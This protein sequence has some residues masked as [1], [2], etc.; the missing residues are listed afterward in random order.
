MPVI[1]VTPAGNQLYLVDLRDGRSSRHEVVLPTPLIERL[2]TEGV[3]MRDVVVAAIEFL[4]D[5]DGRDT[6]PAAI[7]LGEVAREESDGRF[8]DHLQTRAH[9]VT[10]SAP[11]REGPPG[12][13]PSQPS[14]D[15]RLLA[16]VQQDQADGAASR[17]PRK[18]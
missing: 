18:L 17:Q 5:R 4:I 3:A 7:D 12:T 6:L 11:P 10:D 8:V 16:E 1:E 14:G 9:Q 15:D 13:D 2:D